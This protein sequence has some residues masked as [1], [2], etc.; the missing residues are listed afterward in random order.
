MKVMLDTDSCIYLINRR[1][2]MTPQARLQDCCISAIVLGE[3]EFGILK[4]QRPDM[5]RKRLQN[6]L[7]SVV[8]RPVGEA[9]SIAYGEIRL[10]LKTQLIGRN[11]MWIAAHAVS[12]D[13]TLVTN[14]THEFSRVPGLVIDNWLDE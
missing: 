13:L 11:D 5:N 1:K 10:A 9:E 4:S 8:V 12:L 3:L 6:F 7:S 2:G 14:N